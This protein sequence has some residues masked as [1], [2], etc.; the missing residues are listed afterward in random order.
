MD[1]ISIAVDKREEKGKGFSSKLRGEGKIPAVLYGSGQDA[2]SLAIV[3]DVLKKA[4]DNPLRRNTLLSLEFGD[5]KRTALVQEVQID[6]L[7]RRPLHVDFLEVDAEKVITRL[8]PLNLTGK[9]IGVQLGGQLFTLYRHLSVS[10]VAGQ[11]PESIDLDIT[12]L[13]INDKLSISDLPEMEGIS[14][15][16]P[17]NQVLVQLKTAR[18]MEEEEEVEEGEEGVEGAEGAEGDAKAEAPAEDAK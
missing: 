9:S 1:P 11:I 12:E 10:C 14:Y 17:D 13:N 4:L 3:P 2:V 15:H 8:V 16:H 6:P 18:E 7:S 5:E